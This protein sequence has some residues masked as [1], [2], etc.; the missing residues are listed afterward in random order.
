[1]TT[2]MAPYVDFSYVQL[3]TQ[4]EQHVILITHDSHVNNKRNENLLMLLAYFVI[5]TSKEQ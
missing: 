5:D 2:C 1:M 3:H 4:P